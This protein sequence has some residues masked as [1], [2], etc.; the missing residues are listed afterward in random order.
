MI[1]FVLKAANDFMKY[2]LLKMT[3]GYVNLNKPLIIALRLW[4]MLGIVIL[5]TYERVQNKCKPVFLAYTLFLGFNEGACTYYIFS[6]YT[7]TNVMQLMK[8]T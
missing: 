8:Y 3:L 5:T 6:I 1:L 4:S 2:Y 7:L